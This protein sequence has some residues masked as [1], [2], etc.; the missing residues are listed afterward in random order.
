[1]H[2][3]LGMSED[4]ALLATHVLNAGDDA[5]VCGGALHVLGRTCVVVL[6]ALTVVDC[7]LLVKKTWVRARHLGRGSRVPLIIFII[8]RERPKNEM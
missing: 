4:F 8:L 2:L 1:M 5:G 3:P 6:L 7:I